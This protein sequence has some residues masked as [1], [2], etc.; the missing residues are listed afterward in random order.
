MG[1][2]K[3]LNFY[4]LKIILNRPKTVYGISHKMYI[5]SLKTVIK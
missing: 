3:L 1:L 4:K 2:T 5:D